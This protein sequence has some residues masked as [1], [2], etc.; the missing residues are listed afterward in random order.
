ME[1]PQCGGKIVK[2]ED[3]ECCTW[4]YCQD[5]QTLILNDW[6]GG[7]RYLGLLKRFRVA[8]KLLASVCEEGKRIDGPDYLSPQIHRQMR[9]Y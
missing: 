3:I 1:C 8:I 9:A 2:Y 5:C 6:L 7:D 4:F